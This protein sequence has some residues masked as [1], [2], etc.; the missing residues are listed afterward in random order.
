MVEEL[1]VEAVDVKDLLSTIVDN[2]CILGAGDMLTRPL[3]ELVLA[4]EE[5]PYVY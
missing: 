1:K 3:I 2:G 4:I 5:L